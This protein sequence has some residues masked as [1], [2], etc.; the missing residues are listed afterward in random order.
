M[1][2]DST[3]NATMM[4]NPADDA[5]IHKMQIN[6]VQQLTNQLNARKAS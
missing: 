4:Q 1:T 6:N 3:T 2:N 5:Q